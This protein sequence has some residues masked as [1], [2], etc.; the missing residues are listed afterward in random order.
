ME[1]TFGDLIYAGSVT[2]EVTFWGSHN[3]F[4]ILR[5]NIKCKK[6]TL[7][8]GLIPDEKSVDVHLALIGTYD[9]VKLQT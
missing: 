9:R 5:P 7:R 1:V 4:S 3:L 8:V 2:V 6:N